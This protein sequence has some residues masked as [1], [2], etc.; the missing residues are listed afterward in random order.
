MSEG[1]SLK[2]YYA[3]KKKIYSYSS[4]DIEVLYDVKRCIHAEKCIHGLPGVFDPE[5]RPWIEPGKA[6]AEAVAKVVSDCPTGALYF[7]RKDQGEAE[8]VPGQNV[9]KISADGPLYIHGNVTITAATGETAGEETRLAL[10]RCGASANKP[11]CDNSH[12]EAGFK[13]TGDVADNSAEAGDIPLDGTLEMTP[14]LNGPVLLKGNFEIR[15][16]DGASFFRGAKAALCRCGASA[17]KPFCDGAH[18][19]IG[20]SAE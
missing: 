4:D 18:V 5:R 20:F 10:C 7:N 8:D 16:E 2:G 13:A 6:S 11:F 12:I 17:N 3:V 19:K 14:A 9:M 15:S 1:H